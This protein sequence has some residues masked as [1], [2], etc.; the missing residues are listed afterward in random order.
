MTG[1]QTCAL[2]ICGGFKHSTRPITISNAARYVDSPG[3]VAIV[4]NTPFSVLRTS[5][6]KALEKHDFFE[7]ENLDKIYNPHFVPSSTRPFIKENIVIIILE[8]FAREYIGALNPDLEDGNYTGYTPFIDS[9]LGV[10]LTFDV[11]LGNGKKSI[12]AMPSILASLPSLE[13]PYII[14][15]YA[16]NRINGL[17]SLLKRKG[18]YSAFFHGDRKSVV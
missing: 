6:Q 13:T 16:N 10:S 7:K 11:S 8:S 18:Y 5:G 17:A 12:D 1:V 2:P 3:D 4:L 14:S 9:L 15:H